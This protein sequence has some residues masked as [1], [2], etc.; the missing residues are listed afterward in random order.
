[1]RS[2]EKTASPSQDRALI[3]L[4]KEHVDQSRPSL[5]P[6]GM[7]Q[8][9]VNASSPRRLTPRFHSFPELLNLQMSLVPVLIPFPSSPTINALHHLLSRRS[10]RRRRQRVPH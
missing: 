1:M 8:A 4:N 3:E 7:A 6:I 10:R 5:Q 9:P 2:M